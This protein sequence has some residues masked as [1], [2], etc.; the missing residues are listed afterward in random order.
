MNC[1]GV[2]VNQVGSPT[3]YHGLVR[4]WRIPI[5]RERR[6]LTAV[7]GGGRPHPFPLSFDSVDVRVLGQFSKLVGMTMNRRRLIRY[8]AA[9]LMLAGG[10][11]ALQWGRVV[12][13]VGFISMAIGA[14][15]IGFSVLRPTNRKDE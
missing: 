11:R 13:T 12:G 8:I 7:R 10:W 9:V 5:G 2:C 3:S 14:G 15:L 1:V 4:A 6:Y